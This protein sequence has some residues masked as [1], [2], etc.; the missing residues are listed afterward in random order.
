[1]ADKKSR[2]GEEVVICILTLPNPNWWD[3]IVDLHETNTEIKSLKEKTE[4]G[5]LGEQ[6]YVKRRVFF[7]K[8]R[9]YLPKDSDFVLVILQQYH[10]LGH[11]GFYKTFLRIQECF[12]WKNLKVKVKEWVRQCDV[13]QRNK[14]DQQLPSR[15]L[16]P[17][18]IP[19]KIWAEI[20]MDFVEGL[21]KSKEKSITLVVMDRMTKYG[22]FLPLAHPYTAKM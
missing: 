21:P 13:C 10:D 7:Y 3:S 6:W 18:P 15:L 14:Y 2:K 20:L 4:R 16:Q 19:M 8:D 11:E 12:Y 9:V 22:H 17:Q 5:E 1:M